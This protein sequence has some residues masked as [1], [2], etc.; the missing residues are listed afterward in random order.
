MD[1]SERLITFFEA[2]ATPLACV[3]RADGCR[4]GW[5]QGEMFRHFR[6][7]NNGFRVNASL[8]GGRVKHD[9]HCLKPTEMVAE[10]KVFGLSGYYNKN[11]Y[12]ASDISRFKPSEDTGR[13]LLTSQ[14]IES[15]ETFGNSFVSDVQ[16]LIRLDRDIERYMIL[17]LQKARPVDEF[18]RAIFGLR[19][20]D[21][22]HEFAN[23]DFIVRVSKILPLGSGPAPVPPP[24]PVIATP[25]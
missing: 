20:S 2:I 8:A 1:W 16:R 25:S 12:G 5:I 21:I 18:G 3:L 22:E 23:Y 10:L 11:L 7:E 13:L 6:T 15:L 17:V 24:D 19:V 4:E 9:V 14:D